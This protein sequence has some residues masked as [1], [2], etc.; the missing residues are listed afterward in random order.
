[1]TAEDRGFYKPSLS[2]TLL[3]VVVL[4]GILLAISFLR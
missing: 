3:A 4:A 1:M 2:D